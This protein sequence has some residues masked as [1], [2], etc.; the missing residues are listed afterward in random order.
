MNLIPHELKL[1]GK[2]GWGSSIPI[3]T[4]Y[5][6]EKSSWELLFEEECMRP[7]SEAALY[8]CPSCKNVES[9][10]RNSFQRRDL[11]LKI[12]CMFC[13][14]RIPVKSWSCACASQWH[15]CPVHY[16]HYRPNTGDNTCPD[17]H[18]LKGQPS[19]HARGNGIKRKRAGG[20]LADYDAM[21]D[22]DLRRAKAI[23]ARRGGRR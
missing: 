9:S 12:K 14:K 2:V 8:S 3:M 10:L 6:E 13:K 4:A 5:S 19:N 17:S 20:H 11:D 18:P 1:K 15:A 23:K 22:D 16:R 21:L 7:V